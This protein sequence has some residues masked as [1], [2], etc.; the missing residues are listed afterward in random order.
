VSSPD[1]PLFD[2]LANGA[3]PF[4]GFGKV[5]P[6][7]EAGERFAAMLEVATRRVQEVFGLPEARQLDVAAL[8]AIAR[9]MWL[10]GWEPGNG[11]VN[12]FTTDLGSLLTRAL[13]AAFGGEVTFRSTSD[14][15][16][17]SVW[18]PQT[19]VEAFPFHKMYKRLTAERGESL[20]DFLGALE[21]Q[22]HR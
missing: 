4:E 16:H 18:W 22:L 13:V 11:N 5:L 12:L 17:A 1:L 15:S 3:R 8:E 21:V 7:A 14:L 2:I 9:D 20:V 6:D 19:R 10:Q